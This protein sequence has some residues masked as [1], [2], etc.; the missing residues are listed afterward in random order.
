MKL[1][2]DSQLDSKEL[3]DVICICTFG[4]YNE[5]HW[6]S[7]R[8]DIDIMVLSNMELDWQREMDIEDYLTNHLSAYFN[9]NNIHITFLSDFV[10]P[11]GELM[12]SSPNKLVFQEEKYLDYILGYS[13]FKRDRENLEIIRN[14]HLNEARL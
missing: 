4:S 8:S 1:I 13:T 7:N 10:Y 6:D 2:K 9:H 5:E 14:Y 3:S 12:I 11:Y